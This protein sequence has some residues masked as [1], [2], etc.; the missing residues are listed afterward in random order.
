MSEEVD[1]LWEELKDDW[2]G[3]EFLSSKTGYKYVVIK[4]LESSLICSLFDRGNRIY[5]A[6]TTFPKDAFK[7]AYR[8]KYFRRLK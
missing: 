5:T 7:D 2:T 8:R 3:R 4:D 1:L 6:D